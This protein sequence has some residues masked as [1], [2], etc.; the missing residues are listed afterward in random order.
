MAR[1]VNVADLAC[2]NEVD[3][4]VLSDREAAQGTAPR[5]I[6]FRIFLFFFPHY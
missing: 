2:A 1:A 5:I 6:R 4:F 3:E